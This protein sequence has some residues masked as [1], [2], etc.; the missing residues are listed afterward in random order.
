MKCFLCN[1]ITT[2]TNNGPFPLSFCSK[3]KFIKD[4]LD[5]YKFMSYL[6]SDNNS[7]IEK[8]FIILEDFQII[9]DYKNNTTIIKKFANNDFSEVIKLDNA[10]EI[11][12]SNLDTI[13]DKVKKWYIF[14]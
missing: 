4:D 7:I 8:I 14:S 12:N 3:C 6:N 5:F 10:I 13:L 2:I 9:S 11:N 1:K